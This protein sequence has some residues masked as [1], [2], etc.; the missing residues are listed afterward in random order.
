MQ[1]I[2]A[3]SRNYQLDNEYQML[4][5]FATQAQELAILN[6]KLYRGLESVNIPFEVDPEQVLG[7]VLRYQELEK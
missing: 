4:C 3:L 6:R 2:E 1:K 5:D 7:E